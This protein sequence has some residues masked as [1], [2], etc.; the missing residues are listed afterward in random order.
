MKKMSKGMLMTALIC[1][2]VY[3]GGSPVYASELQEFSLD[4]Y[5]VTAARTETKLVDTPANISVVDAQTIEERHYQD[6]SEVLKDVPGANVL[7]MGT[8]AFEKTIALNGDTRVLVLVDGRRVDFSTGV[9]YGRGCVDMGLL[10]DVNLIDRIEVLKGA[11]GALYG[12]DAVGG[13]INII[14]KKA[15]RSYGKVSI[16]MGS[17]GTK[18]YN[19]MYSIKE[20][21]TGVTVSASKYEQDYYKYKNVK[22]NTT[23]RW[24]DG[25]DM[26][27]E[28]L[29]FKINQ[30][31]SSITNLEIGY[32]YSKY[33]GLSVD[34]LTNPNGA[35]RVNKESNNIFAKL[36]WIINENDNGY[37]QIYHN[38][39][40]YH[41]VRKL[42]DILDGD[43]NDKTFGIDIQQAISTSEN[44]KLV[45]G[46]S[47]KKSDILNVSD[48]I[49][50][51]TNTVITK[52]G[53]IYDKKIKNTAYFLNDTWEIAPTWTLNAGVRYDDNSRSGDETTLSAGLNKKINDNDHV[54]INWG[55]VFKTPTTGDMFAVY[56]GN[57]NLK[58][59]TG[60]SWTIGYNTLINND[61]N[62]NISY[63]ESDL[64]N[65]IIWN[66]A[67]NGGMMDNVSKQKKRG[68]E[69]SVAH[70]LN[71]NLDIEASYS[72]IRVKEDKGAGYLK[73]MGYIPNTYRLG[74]RYN[75]GKWNAN[76]WLRYGGGAS[77][78]ETDPYGYG[79]FYGEYADSNYLTVDIAV[80]YKA[81]KDLSF[82]AK[83]YNLFNEAYADFSG[84]TNGAYD[85]PAQ[86]RRFIVGAEY[87]F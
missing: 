11:G 20:G 24:P 81:T 69:L 39:Y 33:E 28:K 35:S 45:A 59:E 6:V 12:S 29:S 1:G 37:V 31:L 58:A 52:R 4:E 55:E 80:T 10:P 23:E 13:V 79:T 82:Y 71:N 5:V 22:N 83:G 30:G 7:D 67:L 86:S 54:Y 63:F 25:S 44:N 66:K 38:E 27:S 73:D 87:K 50:M 47:W 34:S 42:T 8:G 74:V 43:V 2:A 16:A 84:T 61:T 26:D 65:A 75:D 46:F 17:M 57:P 53:A 19:T 85:H 68:I 21:K 56:G 49:D 62:I 32:D 3:L 40:D 78:V 18:D 15:D 36:N 77:T 72:Y 70:K 64:E 48:E 41:T 51:W 14:T 9:S 76:A 60:D